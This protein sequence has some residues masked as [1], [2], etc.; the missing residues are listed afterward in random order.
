MKLIPWSQVES[1]RC[2]GCGDCCKL[3]V[4]VT[5]KEWLDLTRLYGPEL[6]E[7]SISGFYMR[8]TIDD[9][10]P[11]LC[12]F[13]DRWICGLQPMKP[14]ACKIWPFKICDNPR[15][16]KPDE[17]YLKYKSE[18]F[19]VYAFPQCPGISYGKPSE[20]FV[21]RTLPEF[22]EIRLG[23]RRKQFYSTSRLKHTLY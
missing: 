11:F 7:Q 12:R 14:L 5:T 19:Y 13:S 20:Q 21:S 15:Y 23:L 9:R 6:V 18:E 17:A 4:Q 16:G 8:K 3:T 10:C 22:I 2:I 1:W